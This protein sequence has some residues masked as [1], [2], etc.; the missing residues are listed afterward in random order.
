MKCVQLLHYVIYIKCVQL[1]QNQINCIIL[2]VDFNDE[3]KALRTRR[4]RGRRGD[5]K[6]DEKEEERCEQTKGGLAVR[7]AQRWK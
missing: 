2:Y 6:G 4:S 5:R 3:R 1:L 7:Q